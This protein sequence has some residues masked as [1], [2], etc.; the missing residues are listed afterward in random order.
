[1]E[2]LRQIVVA[3]RKLLAVRC[4]AVQC[5]PDFCDNAMTVEDDVFPGIN[6]RLHPAK[7]QAVAPPCVLGH[8]FWT[9]VEPI[10]VYFD[11]KPG[12]DQDVRRGE[13]RSG[14]AL[15]S[16]GASGVMAACLNSLIVRL[17]R[18]L[19]WLDPGNVRQRR[20]FLSAVG[21]GLPF[22]GYSPQLR[23]HRLH[24]VTSLLASA[25]STAS[26][27]TCGGMTAARSQ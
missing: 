1:M 23:V 12:S 10:A 24:T 26:S 19:G 15:T 13:L 27:T 16:A 11:S 4:H 7:G 21:P 20:A 6:E 8:L 2:G 5:V 17:S 22:S 3:W 25:L 9:V 14:P 18:T